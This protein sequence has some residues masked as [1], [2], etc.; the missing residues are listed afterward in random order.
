MALDK[1]KSADRAKIFR[2]LLALRPDGITEAE[3]EKV[4]RLVGVFDK[5]Q[6][7]QDKN[8]KSRRYNWVYNTITICCCA[9]MAAFSIELIFLIH[10]FIT[11][12]MDGP[13][14]AVASFLDTVLTI[15]FTSLSTLF[16]QTK[17]PK[18]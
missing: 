9:L 13:P 12:L 6:E 18:K 11:A 1:F 5:E 15:F 3:E 17:I 14:E 8:V 4:N 10:R 2:K 7:V 16:L